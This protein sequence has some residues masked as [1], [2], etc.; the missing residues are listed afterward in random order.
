MLEMLKSLV[1]IVL[2]VDFFFF[3]SSSLMSIC[4][5]LGYDRPNVFLLYSL[6]W[7]MPSIC[8]FLL[9]LAACKL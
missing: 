6:A 2:A 7:L 4:N 1:N 5:P 8:P 3:F 9:C